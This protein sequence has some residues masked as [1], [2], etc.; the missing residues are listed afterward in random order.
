MRILITLIVMGLS[1]SAFAQY[2]II[3]SSSAGG[4]VD[5]LAR[6]LN[7]GLRTSLGKD[8]FVWNAGGEYG[9]RAV[10]EF[11]AAPANGSHILVLHATVGQ[12]V[13]DVSSL[14]P[15]ALI[16][17]EFA[18]ERYTYQWIGVFAPPGT[19]AAIAMDLERAVLAVVRS[20]GFGQQTQNYKM[21]DDKWVGSHLTPG[22][23]AIL[24]GLVAQSAGGGSGTSAPTGLPGAMGSSRVSAASGSYSLGGTV[25]G[26]E[27]IALA[28]PPGARSRNECMKVEWITSPVPR[29]QAAD[30]RI[31]GREF[32]SDRHY[33]NQRQLVAYSTCDENLNFV[34]GACSE[35]AMLSS[36][37]HVGT[38]FE[39]EFLNRGAKPNLKILLAS[40]Y[41]TKPGRGEDR[42]TAPKKVFVGAWSISDLRNSSGYTEAGASHQR[43]VQALLANMRIVLGMSPGQNVTGKSWPPRSRPLAKSCG[44]FTPEQVWIA[45]Q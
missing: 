9:A 42:R 25:G 29:N 32:F 17:G 12:P 4:P 45:T 27:I 2:K 13:P 11:S 41:S 38:Y 23:S 39:T 44:S 14:V 21:P 24:A 7:K 26:I 20:P 28:P 10:R 15:L 8:Y 3:V 40:E 6:N 37:E 1:N 31:T 43:K 18:A 33:V 19:P 34:A 5:S 36:G 35:D 22:G 16:V 30:G